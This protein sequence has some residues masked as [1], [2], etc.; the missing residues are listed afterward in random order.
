MKIKRQ[1]KGFTIVELV[2][3]IA[4]IGILSA[5]L[6]PTFAVLIRKANISAD[7]KASQQMTTALATEIEVTT[8]EQAIDALE[9]AGYN[10]SGKLMPV[11]KDHS[12]YWYKTH[13]IIVLVCDEDNS[14]VFPTNNKYSEHFAEDMAKT[15]TEKVLFNLEDG[16]IY[17]DVVAKTA[18]D[19]EEAVSNGT[20][21]I[22]LES[23]IT[24]STVLSIPENANVIVDL[25]GKNFTTKNAR[26][27]HLNDGASLTINAQGSRINC[28]AHGLVNIAPG[29]S[30]DVVINGGEY[31]ANYTTA[32]SLIRLRPG[33]TG[34]EVINIT[35]NDVTYVDESTK[36]GSWVVSISDGGGVKYE[37]EFNL[38]VNGGSYTSP[39]GFVVQNATLNNVT[40][41]SQGYAVLVDKE[42]GSA[43][44][45]NCTITTGTKNDGSAFA[46]AISVGY[47]SEIEVK[48]STITTSSYA[49]AIYSSG[50]SITASNTTV[51]LNGTAE[52]YKNTASVDDDAT[53]AYIKIDNVVVNDKFN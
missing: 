3:V 31:I 1:K 51:T 19:F 27:F 40:I 37:G 24:V 22:K 33:G 4:V 26:P 2:I 52:I 25:N 32:A 34:D 11:T 18:K 43:V 30:A 16:A 15:G 53:V 23:D 44:V 10:A 17:V 9:T 13:N 42:N 21:N 14:L 47:N 29:A 6:I 50:G 49:Y 39:Y 28:N 48:N 8:F 36:F 20:K 38:E 46:S 45:N 35:M 5:I 41:N 7:Q 12:F